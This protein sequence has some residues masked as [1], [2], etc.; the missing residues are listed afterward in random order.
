MLLASGVSLRRSAMILG[1]ARKT[2]ERKL[3]FLGTMCKMQNQLFYNNIRPVQ[4]FQFDDL[5]T[6]EH[7]KCKP[8]SV[9][10]AVETHGR[11]ILGF[12]VSK[13]PATG[14]L[15][16]IARRKYGKRQDERQTGIQ[17][18]LLSL[19]KMTAP[20]VRISSDEHPYY[21]PLVR[22]IFPRAR[23][24]QSK[25]ARGSLGGQGELK[26]IKW[27]PLFSLNHTCAM[28]RANVNRLIRKTWCTTK[29]PERLVDHLNIYVFFHNQILTA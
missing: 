19:Q 20:D 26:K 2:I 9:T 23:Y 8:L 6:I 25:G 29:N 14:H 22:E 4:D 18:L 7:S 21:A 28:L 5:Q 12:E 11:K 27:D 1:V 15:A 3:V 13:M 17:K 24:Q 16:K 10:L